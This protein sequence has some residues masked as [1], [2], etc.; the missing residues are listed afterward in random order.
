MP[1]GCYVRINFS[2]AERLCLQLPAP[3]IILIAL[4]GADHERRTGACSPRQ[5]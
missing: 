5:T 2:V 3:G 4:A 1:L